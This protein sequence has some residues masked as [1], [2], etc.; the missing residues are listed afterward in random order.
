MFQLKIETDNDAFQNGD[1][2]AEIARI[3]VNLAETVRELG[4]EAWS[5]SIRDV[6]GNVVGYWH[7]K[8]EV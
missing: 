6:N 1:R 4:D 5:D 8:I 3:L 2:G 7:S